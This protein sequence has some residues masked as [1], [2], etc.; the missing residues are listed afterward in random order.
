MQFTFPYPKCPRR[1]LPFPGPPFALG[2]AL[3]RHDI[4]S[5]RPVAG[6]LIITNFCNASPSLRRLVRT[7]HELLSKHLGLPRSRLRASSFIMTVGSSETVP[8]I[9]EI[10]KE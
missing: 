4:Y 7:K 9:S 2:P 10:W 5:N 6:F 3:V 1:V 8:S